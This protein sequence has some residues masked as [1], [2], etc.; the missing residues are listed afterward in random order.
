MDAAYEREN[1]IDLVLTDVAETLIRSRS[2][3]PLWLRPGFPMRLILTQKR[4]DLITYLVEHPGLHANLQKSN[5][6]LIDAALISG[7][8]P[9]DLTTRLMASADPYRFVATAVLA[10]DVALVRAARKWALDPMTIPTPAPAPDEPPDV[11]AGVELLGEDAIEHQDSEIS[12]LNVN[13][14][15]HDQDHL[16]APDGA[17]SVATPEVE[18][19]PDLTAVDEKS[20]LAEESLDAQIGEL[21]YERDRLRVRVTRLEGQLREAQAKIPTTNQ[22]R[23]QNKQKGKL[24]QAERELEAAALRLETAGR[25]LQDLRRERDRLIQVRKEVEDQ[26]AE[27]EDARSIA[28]RKSQILERQLA[29]PSGRAGY[30]PEAWRR[31]SPN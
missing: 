3:R 15:V 27:A 18:D 9:A 29:S 7:V 30:L 8:E 19:A 6:R 1:V 17:A 31:S 4:S 26:L 22:R 2:K 5:G 12:A 24:H 23:R 11:S 10:D 16:V 13:M 14:A 21:T 20:P 25:E 28:Q